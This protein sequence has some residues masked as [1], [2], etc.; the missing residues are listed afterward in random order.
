MLKFYLLNLFF[1]RRN[2]PYK[3]TDNLISIIFLNLSNIFLEKK[4]AT[5][6]SLQRLWK[7][8]R[9]RAIK[10]EASGRRSQI[11]ARKAERR[12]QRKRKTN[13]QAI[14]TILMAKSFVWRFA[15]YWVFF[16]FICVV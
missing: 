10:K 13:S 2:Q 11:A 3:N 1:G 16:F 5:E 7:K 4:R 12:N 15:F 8:G 9:R 6:K 14:Q